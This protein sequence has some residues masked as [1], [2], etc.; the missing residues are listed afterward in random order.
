M[1]EKGLKESKTEDL[2]VF[3]DTPGHKAFSSMRERGSLVTDL[4]VL[5][6]AADDG[7]MEQTVESIEFARKSE[8]PIIVAINKI[9]KVEKE[10]DAH[11][12]VLKH[13]LQSHGIVLEEDAGDVQSVRISAL[14]GEGIH[15][16]KEAIL[17]QAET[18][19]LKAYYD[20]NVECYVLESSIDAHRGRLATL[21]VKSGTLRRGD[22]LV[23]TNPMHGKVSWAKIRSM[24]NEYGQVVNEV[25][26]GFPIQVIGWRDDTLPEAG[27][28][29]WQVNSEKQVK[30]L[31][32]LARTYERQVK[33]S[34]DVQV[35]K[36]KSEEHNKVYKA[37][38]AAL[39]EAGIRFKR[40]N[41]QRVKQNLTEGDELKTSVV[42]K[43]DVN[44]TLEVLLDIFD[45]F[46]NETCPAKLDLVHYGLGE[47]SE[48]DIELASC[49]PNGR[50]YTF[51][52]GVFTPSLLK[53]SKELGIPVRR[54]NVLYH[55]VDDLKAVVTE[56]MPFVEK[57]EV[58]GEA[59]VQQ[60]F[61]INEKSKKT[62]VAGSLCIKGVLK[63]DAFFKLVRKGTVLHDRLTLS[64]MRHHKDEVDTIKNNMDCGL[65]FTNNYIASTANKYAPA[66][67]CIRF[68]QQDTL[69][70]YKLV[71]VKQPLVWSPKGL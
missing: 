64:S 61:V 33:E 11:L 69:I 51:N 65:L 9:D 59:I 58:L 22:I 70:C 18:L 39:R 54:F 2:V 34:I 3:L 15:S 37:E 21:L 10:L 46:P 6:V 26:P 16:L 50:I 28:H 29:V 8:V 14:R 43:A 24:F 57:E 27:D 5:V 30:D 25:T 63:K 62:P 38:L 36:K 53:L 41:A 42:L 4:V 71:K 20:G 56:K 12:K 40:K 23:A 19:E 67:R 44:G 55:L 17:A 32:Q 49:F 68:G 60:E 52:T 7:V 1:E 48:N 47:V 13:G 35:I 66:D 45:S 31:L